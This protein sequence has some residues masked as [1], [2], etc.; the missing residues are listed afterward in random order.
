MARLLS[1]LCAVVAIHVAVCE[2][3]S[4]ASTKTPGTMSDEGEADRITKFV[5]TYVAEHSQTP[6]PT[7]TST[8]T[9]TST[10]TTATSSSSITNNN[11]N[12][13]TLSSSP[14]PPPPSPACLA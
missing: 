3:E 8:S 7:S 4:G 5:F 1:L 14:P 9:S 13:T 2:A 11:T 6:P 12:T 10:T